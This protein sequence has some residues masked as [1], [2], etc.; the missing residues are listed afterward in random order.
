MRQICFLTH[1]EY[2]QK[3]ERL[4]SYQASRILGV[5]I[6]PNGSSNK[7]TMQ[8]G[9]MTKE[10]DNRVRSEHIRKTNTWY[11]YHSTIKKLLEYPL[12]TTTMS[13]S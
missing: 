2:P 1:P 7:Q 3:I 8:L 6:D 13:Q 5:W 11:Y 10:W 9:S 4:P 12:V